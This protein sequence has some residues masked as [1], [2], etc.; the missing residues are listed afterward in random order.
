MNNMKCPFCG[1]V[2]GQ[3][4]NT[5][6]FCCRNKACDFSRECMELHVWQALIDGKKARAALI[7]IGKIL[8]LDSDK[9]FVLTVKGKQE[10]KRRITSIMKGKDN[11]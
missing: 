9:P 4:P 3:V 10:I 11:E 6:M 2:L 1:T 8:L 7:G 5:L